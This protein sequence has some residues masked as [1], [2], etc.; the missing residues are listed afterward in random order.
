MLFPTNRKRP[1]WWTAWTGLCYTCVIQVH[2]RSA[3]LPI[4]IIILLDQLCFQSNI[5]K[6][7]H[8]KPF[9]L[10][11]NWS[12][13]R[14]RTNSAV[15][16]CSYLSLYC[17]S[18]LSASNGPFLPPCTKYILYKSF[19]W[20][21]P[22]DPEKN[23]NMS[24]QTENDSEKQN[25]K[26]KMNPS[27]VPLSLSGTN[28]CSVAAENISKS[29]Q[30]SRDITL[31]R[32]GSNFFFLSNSQLH[33]TKQEAHRE[34]AFIHFQPGNRQLPELIKIQYRWQTTGGSFS[35]TDVTEESDEK[36][37][38]TSFPCTTSFL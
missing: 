17:I 12:H 10:E 30:C 9:S 26:K 28:D 14:K 19:P 16:L 8:N 24:W 7:S 35:D 15:G 21:A 6:I 18:P 31:F 38:T 32:T 13:E 5:P 2:P 4:I 36:T 20:W 25:W 3:L 22:S 33:N 37:P 27:Q 1:W 23:M 11:V 29:N 34:A